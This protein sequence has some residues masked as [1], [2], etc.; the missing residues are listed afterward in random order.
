MPVQVE[1]ENRTFHVNVRQSAKT[2]WVATGAIDGDSI[3][4]TARTPLI[5]ARRWR[6]AVLRR[7]N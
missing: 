6:S 3:K 5:A 1:I 7:A 4:T 2:I